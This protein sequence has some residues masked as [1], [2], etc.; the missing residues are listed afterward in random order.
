MSATALLNEAAGDFASAGW[1][2][3]EAVLFIRCR[4]VDGCMHQGL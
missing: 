3:R 2:R 4:A 1:R